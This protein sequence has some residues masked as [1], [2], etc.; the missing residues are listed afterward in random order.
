VLTGE[1][2]KKKLKLVQAWAEIH[3]DELMTNWT[4]ALE[5]E[6]LFRIEPLK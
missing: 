5:G 3:Q 2:P 4:L 1:F 6:Q